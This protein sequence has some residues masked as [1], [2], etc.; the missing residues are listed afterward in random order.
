MDE[1]LTK[2]RIQSFNLCSRAIPLFLSWRTLRLC[3][4]TDRIDDRLDRGEG[5]A[6][7]PIVISVSSGVVVIPKRH[8]RRPIEMRI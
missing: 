6:L 8:V 4:R 2:L 3:E 5:A 7:Q 1:P